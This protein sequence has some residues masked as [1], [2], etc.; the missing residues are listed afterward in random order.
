MNERVYAYV[1]GMETADLQETTTCSFS[2]TVEARD[3]QRS[4]MSDSRFTR[5]YDDHITCN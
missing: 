1:N 3:V 4:Q 5:T 2:K